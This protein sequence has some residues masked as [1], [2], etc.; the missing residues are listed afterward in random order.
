MA[1]TGETGKGAGD[2]GGVGEQPRKAPKTGASERIGA[3]R[4]TA[5]H[6]YTRTKG[7][8]WPLYVIARMI[9]V[10]AF[11]IWFRLERLG[12]EH[13]RVEGGLIV[14]SN[15]R[16]FLDPFVLGTMLP[17]KRP[18]HYVAKVELFETA[19]QGWL[20]S[21]LGAYPVRR[22][23]ADAETLETSRR[24]L[25]RGGALC[26]FPEGT[27]IR[28][29]SL[30]VPHRGVG[31]LALESGAAVLPVAVVGSERVRNGW[32]IR[33]RKVRLRAGRPMTFPRTENPSPSLAA[34]VTSR[35]WPNIELQWEWLGGLPPMRK[36]AV[37]GAGSWGTAVAVLLA[38]GGVEVQLGCRTAEQAERVARERES[39]Y[40]PGIGL[41]DSIAVK[42]AADI[43]VAGLD[44][45]CL[46]VPSAALP[47]AVGAL[48]DRVGSRT[49]V[50]LLSKGLVPPLGTLPSEY[51]DERIRA[52]AIAALGGPAHAGEAASGTAAL[53]LATRDEDLRAQL[54][55]VFVRAGLICERSADVIGVEMAGAAKNAASLAAAAAA[56]HGLNAAGIA[57]AEIWRECL[58]YATI[59]GGSP[60]T[61]A[62]L[63]GVGDLT[64]TILAP[65]SRNRRAG[66][67]LGSG[68]PAEQIPERIGQASEGLDSVPLIAAAVERAGVEA[69]G[70]S[71]LAALIGG[72]MTAVEWVEGL[73]RAERVRTAA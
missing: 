9:L 34:T 21:R 26:I 43:E 67:L 35:I 2:G 12:R 27:R 60:E 49:A 3:E 36:A 1:G 8:N 70:L 39:S 62:G 6:E 46:A 59:R 16:S 41:A 42:R 51:V 64:A 11:L 66:E 65:G 40:L 31:R 28:R 38:R 73:R 32:R 24:I 52:R 69:G 72:E 23:E 58:A 68:V 18:M 7:V 50:L 53:A 57:A 5:Y 19:W 4:I 14:A 47:A 71:G 61:F 13:A 56:P 29:G 17:W 20:L 37:I 45:V 25:E 44:L 30:A 63:A 15:H 54:G 33:P 48:S 22:G 10:P 55:D